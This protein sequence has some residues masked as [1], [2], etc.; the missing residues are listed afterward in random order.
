LVTLRGV[1]RPLHLDDSQVEA[2][3]YHTLSALDAT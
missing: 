1:L 2:V 3:K